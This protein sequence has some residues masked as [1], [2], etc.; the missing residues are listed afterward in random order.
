MEFAG[1][2]EWDQLPESADTL[3]ADA[4]KESIFLSRTWLE[5]LTR[6][7][8][9]DD[10]SMLLA[11][12]V[13]GDRVLAIL[14]LMGRDGEH[15]YSLGHLYTSLFSLSLAQ[16]D[17]QAILAC[18]VEGLSRL[19]AHSLR[20]APVAE[21][22]DRLHSLQKAMESSGFLCHRYFRF[23]NWIHRLQDE[24]FADYMAA[25]PTRVRN[26][27]AR[28]R[29]KLEREH[30]YC[31][32]LYTGND[33]Q[34]GLA[35][36]NAVHTASWKAKELFGGFVEGIAVS[37]SDRG[38]LR[39]AVLYIEEKP[40]AAQFWFVAHG[41]ASIFK[42]A[43]DEAWKRYSPGS[44]LISYLMEHVIDTDKVG[45]IDFLTGNDA[46]KMDWMTDRRV[47]WGL[48]CGKPRQPPR[49]TAGLADTVKAWVQ[50]LKR[51]GS[52]SI[53]SSNR[54]ANLSGQTLD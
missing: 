26:T 31:I 5:N 38:W 39:L 43:Y 47:R 20:L 3:F 21:D 54:W 23:Y 34:K 2:T 52:S 48:Y 17:R 35:D 12:V 36:Y 9:E 28:K 30:G 6:S 18:L 29:R 44:I 45:E 37:L 24:T 33:L 53:F 25:R 51:A 1:Y 50:R 19:P 10:Q 11:F 27:I 32:R 42:L 14:P 22:D 13:R 16:N 40:A 49:R 41:K 4:E 8:L 7:A 46:Y 15:W